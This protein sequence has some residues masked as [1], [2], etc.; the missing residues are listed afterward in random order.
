MNLYIKKISFLFLSLAFIFTACETEESIQITSPDPALVLQQPGISNVFLNFGTPSNSALTISWNDD[1]TGSS[2]YDV[3]MSLDADFTSTVNLGN[4]SS[5]SFSI[6][7]EDLNTAIR[8]GGVSTFKDIAVYVRVNAGSAISNTVL[9][10]VTTYPTEVPQISSPSANDAFVLSIGSLDAIAITIDWTDAVLASDLGIDVN[11]TIQAAAAGTDFADPFTIGTSTNGTTITSTHSDFN[12][13]AIAIG[14][15]PD[16]A[17]DM[18]IRIIA[19]NTN[20]NGNVLERVSDVVTISVTSFSVSFP[21]LY[22]VGD[23]TTPGWDN[24]NNNTVVFRNQDVPNAYVYTGYFKAGA[25]KLLENKGEWHPQWG[26]NDGTTLA[27]SNP[28]GSNEPG[29]FNVGTAG[30]YTY[31]F[32]T[33]AESGSFSVTP[34]DAS[35]ATTYTSMDIIGSA[36]PLSWDN[37]TN[38]TQD[39]NNPHLWFL[40]DVTLVNGEF[41]IRANGNWDDAIFR[42]TGSTE[43]YGTARLDNA[44]GD[45]FPF[46]EITGSYNLWFN[47]L[48]GSYVIIPN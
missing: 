36:T 5:K 12:A 17:G 19:K 40:N 31:N 18:E 27:V 1:L 24:N 7:V 39:P 34:F 29:T 10:L 23:A 46:N 26:T 2:S 42:Y 11:F 33:V 32:T 47:D 13:V 16:I 35:G 20:E 8:A 38:F 37:G 44:G 43:L 6:S 48:D 4:V 30:Y 3:E 21:N 25:F 15:T 22:M 14:L 45:N 28:D 41:L 9:Y